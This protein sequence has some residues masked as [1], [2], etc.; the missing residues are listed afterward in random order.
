MDELDAIERALD[1]VEKE[2]GG[3]LSKAQES[4]P[5]D[6]MIRK[7]AR[8]YTG[9][10]VEQVETFE[11]PTMATHISDFATGIVPDI[12]GM[13]IGGMGL[14]AVK[15]AW[16]GAPLLKSALM[17]GEKYGSI[18]LERP[19]AKG[20]SY[21]GN[22]GKGL[23]TS[24]SDMI[25]GVVKPEVV[26]DIA[27]KMQYKTPISH[28]QDIVDVFSSAGKLPPGPTQPLGLPR[29]PIQMPE[30]PMKQIPERAT[31]VFNMGKP[32]TGPTEYIGKDVFGQKGPLPEWMAEPIFSKTAPQDI[33]D[34][35]V[36]TVSKSKKMGK[37]ITSKGKILY[38][39]TKST[40]KMS[41]G[42]D[43]TLD[44]LFPGTYEALRKRF[45]KGKK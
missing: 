38:N 33:L 13:G 40:P 5:S 7:L 9:P 3:G 34:E 20:V 45:P 24:I 25:R 11:K 2:S 32:R 28:P 8:G 4:E 16:T 43:K 41:Q 19:I 22:L 42:E 44:E 15:A 17:A 23:G 10:S 6:D 36:E 37:P 35:V 1:Q 30:V 39:K 29:G 21:L 14:G 27:S 12:L 18:G 26:G 31:Q